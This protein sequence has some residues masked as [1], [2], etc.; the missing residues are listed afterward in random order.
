M[1][2]KLFTLRYSPTL[3]GF[4]ETPLREFARDKELLAVKD[5]FFVA[6]GVPHLSCLLTYQDPVVPPEVLEAARELAPT[7]ASNGS[8]NRGRK[9]PT[10]GLDDAERQLY[11]TL[12]EWRAD[13]A[14]EDG[15]PPY[16]ILTNR[17]L[18]TVIQRRPDSP[19]ALSGLEGIGPATVKRYGA[20]ILAALHGSGETAEA[21]SAPE[22]EQPPDAAA[23]AAASPNEQDGANSGEEANS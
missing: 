19:T 13:K 6:D 14:R 8:R 4:D 7:A 1:R 23:A 5:H 10:A 20:D 21:P 12:R 3:G 15:V 9:D 18:V 11:N 22:A 16:V 17:Q 2:V